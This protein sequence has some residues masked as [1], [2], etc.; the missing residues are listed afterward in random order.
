MSVRTN[1]TTPG[2][3]RPELQSQSDSDETPRINFDSSE[4]NLEN[5][6]RVLDLTK[7]VGQ[8]DDG[9]FSGVT[10]EFDYS[11][12]E[13]DVK[14]TVPIEIKLGSIR[15][16]GTK[17]QS[18]PIYF[19]EIEDLVSEGWNSGWTMN[20]SPRSQ[21]HDSMGS[22]GWSLDRNLKELLEKTDFSP[23]RDELIEVLTDH[24]V[25]NIEIVKVRSF[26]EEV[27]L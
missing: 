16:R 19:G 17:S 3:T 11:E 25:S 7:C 18:F 9:D 21:L 6:K 15:I 14:H 23:T 1:G 5:S 24:Q 10:T 22:V 8:T 20:D 12:I 2:T 13:V 26:K 4:I 27:T